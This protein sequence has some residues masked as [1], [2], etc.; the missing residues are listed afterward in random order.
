MTKKNINMKFKI[1]KLEG[2]RIEKVHLSVVYLGDAEETKS[3]T[4]A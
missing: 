3:E 4:N 2:H 1:T